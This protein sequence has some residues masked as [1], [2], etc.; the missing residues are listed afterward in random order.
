MFFK[1]CRQAKKTCCHMHSKEEEKSQRN[2]KHIIHIPSKNEEN[3]TYNGKEGKYRTSKTQN[4]LLEG[5][6]LNRRK[7][8]DNTQRHKNRSC[9]H[10]MSQK[11][12]LGKICQACKEKYKLK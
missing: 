6:F 8:K 3:H 1:G 5:I 2:Q 7:I 10:Y 12:K 11:K 9:I 4:L